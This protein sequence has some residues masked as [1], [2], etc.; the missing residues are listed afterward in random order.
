MLGVTLPPFVL[1]PLVEN[2]IH[3]GLE[4]CERSGRLEITIED[5]DAEAFVS[6]EDNGVERIPNT[7]GAP[8][9]A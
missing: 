8:C 2:A 7:C 3:H 1:Q 6:V 5:A 9:A 4:P